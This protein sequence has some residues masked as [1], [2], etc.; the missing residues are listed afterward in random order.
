MLILKTPRR[1]RLWARFLLIGCLALAIGHCGTTTDTATPGPTSFEGPKAFI[2]ASASLGDAGHS[3][4]WGGLAVFDYDN[5]GNLDLYITNGPGFANRLLK[6]DGQ[7]NF[8]DVTDEAGVGLPADNCV[9]CAVG[10]FNNDG[11]LDMLVGRQ[12]QDVPSG[13]P[14]GAVMLLNNGPNAS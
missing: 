7:G 6:N 2:D 12:K 8:T 5:D 14:V 13:A 4:G 1:L 10:D 11:W 3:H 9:A